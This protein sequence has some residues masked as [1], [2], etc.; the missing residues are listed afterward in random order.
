MRLALHGGFGEKG[1][2]SV[3]VEARGYRVLLDAGVKTSARGR[4]DYW[5]AISREQLA[6]LDAIVVSHAHEDHVGALGWCLAQGFAGRILMTAGTR[7]ECESIVT[8]Y[9]GAEAARRLRD[10]TIETFTSGDDVGALGPLR[11]SAGRS[12]HVAGGVWC[13]LDDGA[14][15]LVYCGDVVPSS[16]VFAMDPL[17]PCDALILDASYGDDA[18]TFA[19]RAAEVAAWVGAHPQGAILPTPR[20]GRSLELFALLRSGAVLAPGMR[21]ALAA[22]LD[23]PEWLVDGV[24]G[25]LRRALARAPS[26]GVDEPLPRAPVLCDDGMGMSGPSRELLRLAERTG[27]PVLLTGH[28]PDGSPAHR[29]LE[30]GRAAWIRLPTH[31]TLAENVAL[32]AATSAP[33]VL[34]HSCEPDALERLA[35]RVPNLRADPATGDAPDLG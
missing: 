26:C 33:V 6:A 18:T 22:Q 2:T 23:A 25:E 35:R 32:A 8:A 12:G 20:S 34:G 14:R 21:E 15:R 13:L 4:P 27:H 16:P 28:V 24:A 7:A 10:A 11:F 3:G 9:D 5:P 30:A 19:T 31:P 29:M 17:P 1:R